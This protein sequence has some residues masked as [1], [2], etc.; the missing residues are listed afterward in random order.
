MPAFL[1]APWTLSFAPSALDCAS[2]VSASVVSLTRSQPTHSLP[3]LPF[4]D[5]AGCDC[6][7]CCGCGAAD[8]AGAGGG[9]AAAPRPA[10]AAPPS[11]A[12]AAAACCTSGTGNDAYEG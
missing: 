9:A 8:A 7:G 5:G 2:V 6:G 10:A 11:A 12:A 4:A 1:A 3:R